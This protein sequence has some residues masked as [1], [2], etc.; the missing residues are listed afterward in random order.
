MSEETSLQASFW[1]MI[2]LQTMGSVDMPG[3]GDRKMPSPRAYLAT[4]LIWS[5]L[6]VAAD[7]GWDRPARVSAWLIVLSGMVFGPFGAKIVNLFTN[8][9]SAASG[10]GSGLAPSSGPATPQTSRTGQ[11][12]QRRGAPVTTP[13]GANMAPNSPP[14]ITPPGADMAP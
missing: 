9:A 14:T 3:S 1:L 8:V 5:V 4:I 7:A 11:P 2:V 13:A 6:Q 12:L 10:Q